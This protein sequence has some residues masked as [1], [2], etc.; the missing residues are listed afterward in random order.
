MAERGKNGHGGCQPITAYSMI[1]HG[2][3]SVES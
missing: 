3:E 1:P 2:L